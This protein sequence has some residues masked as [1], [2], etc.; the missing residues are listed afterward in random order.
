M[1]SPPRSRLTSRTVRLI[2]SR[3]P[4]VGVFDDIAGSEEDLRA[5]FELED[6]TNTRLIETDRLRAIP[7]GEVPR[8]AVGASLVMAAFL[9]ASEEGGRF[10]DRRLGAWYAATEVET[11]LAETIY[12][13]ER[14]LRASAAG[15]PARIQ[16]RELISNIDGDLLDVRG[17]QANE[18]GLYHPT[19]YSG[20]Q[21]F[22]AAYRWPFAAAREEGVIY[23]SVRRPA[24][25]N[26]CI[27]RPMSVTLPV[28]QGAH[29]DYVWDTSG[30]LT[31]LELKNVI[32]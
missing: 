10:S 22:A 31:I 16:M 6:L 29:Y 8:G 3:Y 26:V 9:H 23:D 13:H 25:I 15:F 30:S 14:R 18:P 17:Q 27:W 2:A 12:H 19:D 24:G 11:A 5:A 1:T 32:I 28:E 21:G 20:S 4:A 7:G